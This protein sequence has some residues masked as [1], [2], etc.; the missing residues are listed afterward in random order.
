MSSELTGPDELP[1]L[2]QSSVLA[3]LIRRGPEYTRSFLLENERRE[4]P[5]AM[6]LARQALAWLEATAASAA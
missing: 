1:S 5:E 6:R 4:S 2:I 3:A